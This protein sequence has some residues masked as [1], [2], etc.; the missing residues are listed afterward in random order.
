MEKRGVR[1]SG[2]AY[3]LKRMEGQSG[4]FRIVH[5]IVGVHCSGVF[6]KWSS[7]VIALFS[8]IAAPSICQ[9]RNTGGGKG[10]GTRL[11]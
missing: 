2:V 10:L 5:Y 11:D 4:I 1:Y 6:V 3:A 9:N 7:V 8:T